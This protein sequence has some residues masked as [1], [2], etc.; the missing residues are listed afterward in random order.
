MLVVKA[1][2]RQHDWIEIHDMKDE[3]GKLWK[4]WI[5]LADEGWNPPKPKVN[6]III[7]PTWPTPL[8]D[9]R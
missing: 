9:D 6:E 7:I 2:P 3:R 5:K 4:Y 8:T 1:A